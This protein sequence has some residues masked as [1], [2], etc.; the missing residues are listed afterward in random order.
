MISEI[1]LTCPHC[2]K[3]T[4]KPVEWIQHNT[5]FTCEFC[6]TSVLIDKDVAAEL[7]ARL[8]LQQRH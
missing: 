7:L 1:P 5:F 8:E 2:Q 6:G 3:V 4:V